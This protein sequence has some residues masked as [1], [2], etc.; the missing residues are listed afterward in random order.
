M[1]GDSD[2]ESVKPSIRGSK[3][4]KKGD[5]S[6]IGGGGTGGTNVQAHRNIPIQ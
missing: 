3:A 6:A 2:A 1:M 5:K 4:N